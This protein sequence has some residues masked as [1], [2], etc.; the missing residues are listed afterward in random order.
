MAAR[1]AESESSAGLVLEAPFTSASAVAG[2]VLP[3]WVRC[4]FVDTDMLSR[5][6]RVRVPVLIV[7]GDSD[8]LSRMIS[9]NNSMDAANSPKSL[10]TVRGAM[11]NDLH[12]VGG[13]NFGRS[14]VRILCFLREVEFA[15]G[16]DLGR[17]WP[18]ASSPSQCRRRTRRLRYALSPGSSPGRAPRQRPR[19][20]VEP[21]PELIVSPAPRSK[22]RT[23]DW[24]SDRR[25]SRR[26]H[27]CGLESADGARSRAA[28]LLPPV[29]NSSTKTAHC[30]LPTFRIVHRS[31][32]SDGEGPVA[33]NYC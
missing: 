24:C 23:S 1:V 12:V 32:V 21:V 2:R 8:E 6:G 29:G 10:W 5:I 18:M 3:C 13:R 15:F 11:H 27:L 9:G 30:G 31:P 4:W 28:D 17:T 20:P 22:K 19:Q 14:I 16:G 25:A 33:L 7:H 26:K